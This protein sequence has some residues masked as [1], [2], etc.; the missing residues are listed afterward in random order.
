MHQYGIT[1]EQCAQVVVKNRKNAK[2]NPY[3]HA[4]MD[5][6][7]EEVLASRML[8]PPSGRWMSTR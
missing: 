3:A 5:L 8:L 6:T 1:P 2:N 4:P 7:V